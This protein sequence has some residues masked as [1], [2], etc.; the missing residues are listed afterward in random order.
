MDQTPGP[1]WSTFLA[2]AERCFKAP[3]VM[4]RFTS[5]PRSRQKSSRTSRSSCW[6]H[7]TSR[8]GAAN[9]RK[10]SV[11]DSPAARD[12]SR[13]RSSAMFSAA[14]RKPVSGS[15]HPRFGCMRRNGVKAQGSAPAAGLSTICGAGRRSRGGEGM[16]DLDGFE[17]STSSM[18]WRT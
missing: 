13:T 3:A 1:N 12:P 8:L 6:W 4:R 7:P 15:R 18:P 2:F 17:P 10:R 5:K 14:L 9:C 11:G 16:V